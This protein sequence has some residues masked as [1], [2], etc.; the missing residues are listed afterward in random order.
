MTTRA[1]QQIAGGGG[2]LT[3][4][5]RLSCALTALQPVAAEQVA[6]QFQ[7]SWEP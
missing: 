7:L 1:I 6:N 4:W 3:I 2:V 5:D